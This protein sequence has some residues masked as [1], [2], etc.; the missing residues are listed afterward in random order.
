MDKWEE[1]KQY[2]QAMIDHSQEFIDTDDFK[3]HSNDFLRGV[4]YMAGKNLSFIEQDSAD[5]LRG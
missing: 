5:A 3:I 2:N 1:L 4:Q